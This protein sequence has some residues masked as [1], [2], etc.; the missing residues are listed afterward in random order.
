[1][2]FRKNILLF[3]VGLIFFVMLFFLIFES[4]NLLTTMNHQDY[5]LETNNHQ[6]MLSSLYAE[7]DNSASEN[8]A[9]A[10][11]YKAIEIGVTVGVLGTVIIVLLIIY[12]I[13]KKRGTL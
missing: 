5:G 6:L 13:K 7:N 9:T 3:F 11:H 10:A 8:A 2:N 12:F 1:M 4:S